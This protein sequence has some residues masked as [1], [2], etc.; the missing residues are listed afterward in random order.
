[1][2]LF[3]DILLPLA[4]PKVLTYSIPEELSGD[5]AP[6]QRVMVQLGKSKILA[7]L[8]WKI[9]QD[10]P[11]QD[12]RPIIR[13]VDEK[14]ILEPRQFEF[15]EWMATYYL[16]TPGEVMKAALPSLLKTDRL[17]TRRKTAGPKSKKNIINETTPEE[18]QNE[19]VVSPLTPSQ[20]AV[21]E[22]FKINIENKRVQL[23][24]GI[25][26]SGKT[27]IYIHL[28]AE[29]MRQNRQ[30][31][32]LLPEIAITTQIISRLESV[33]G[34]RL[35]IYHSRHTPVRRLKVWNRILEGPQGSGQL[36]LGVRSS[37]F[38]PFS[39]LGLIIVDEEHEHSY[40]QQDPA[41]RYHARDV[42]IVLAN[43]HQVPVLMGSATPS[44]ES[45]YAAHGGKYA[46]LELNERFGGVEMPEI[47]ISGTNE[48]RK[49]KQMQGSFTPLMLKAI[50]ETLTHGEQVILFHNR[51]G[52]SPYI[53]CSECKYIPKCVSCDVSLTYHRTS[54]MLECHH[55]GYRIRV[56]DRC[57]E[58][59][60]T[61]LTTK[62]LGTERVEDDLQL[63][64]P[65]A[66][67]GR[68][69]LDSTRKASSYEQILTSFE[70]GE[71]DILIGT[72]MI[73][74][75]LDFSRVNLVGI[76]NADHL[77]NFPDFRSH[78][79]SFQLMT[80][81]SGRAGRRQT[82]GLVV[83]QVSDP[84]H[85]VVQYV[86]GNNLSGFYHSELEERRLFSYPPFSR[87][88]RITL[89]HSK[90]ETA[91]IAAKDL[92]TRLRASLGTRVLGPQVP[93]IGKVQDRY[94][95]T[96]LI[97]LERSSE[98]THRKNSIASHIKEV[99]T[100]KAYGHLII[101][102]DVDPL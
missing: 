38:L 20:Q 32:F 70:S 16:C 50:D 86:A 14:P 24:H 8:I 13:I 43:L 3:A 82:R 49:R 27:E 60:S 99:E 88:I 75:G 65:S 52:Y 1:M 48:A 96:L 23:L 61:G 98:L 57:P 26:S 35:L 28:I 94:L 87:L 63:L 40:K 85:P 11:T 80:Q 42:A 95:Q 47:I 39:N 34:D 30:V 31:L 72:Q 64:F 15:W 97:K 59:G 93:L 19:P 76:I 9:H 100:S 74:K 12:A 45:W 89:K 84:E 92:G 73:S 18:Q 41:P 68:L 33:F 4:L 53:E 91:A 5:A 71:I 21:F 17:E 37:V 10:A 101:Q 69:D 90:A 78:E 7:G 58:C 83:I 44:L 54:R 25:T 22:E 55:C 77:L 51:R 2:T 36:I 6:G 29:Q 102:A 56:P 66:R 81:V 46:L 62:G 79:R 67:I